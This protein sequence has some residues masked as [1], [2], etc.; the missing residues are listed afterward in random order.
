MNLEFPKKKKR[1]R[2]TTKPTP[3]MT[4]FAPPKVKGDRDWKGAPL[5]GATFPNYFAEGPREKKRSGK[6]GL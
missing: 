2:K 6:K 5:G 4:S 3:Q 1:P